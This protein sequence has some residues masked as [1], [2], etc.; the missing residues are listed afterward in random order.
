MEFV[1]KFDEEFAEV[2]AV[3]SVAGPFAIVKSTE[4]LE[5]SVVAFAAVKF[6]AELT[7]AGL[8]EEESAA[9]VE[10][11]VGFAVEK[12][13]A[14]DVEEFAVVAQVFA[15]AEATVATPAAVAA[16]LVVG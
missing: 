5:R 8:F 14:F 2:V 11:F 15:F 6:G 9:S 16:L 12:S 1:V 7:V 10:R 4:E 3:K 13:V